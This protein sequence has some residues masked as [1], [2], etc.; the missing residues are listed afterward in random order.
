MTD[1]VDVRP[2][3]KALAEAGSIGDVKD[4]RDRAAAAEAYA[5]EAK[6][7]E[8]MDHA[9]E[10]RLTAERKAGE[11]LREMAERGEREGRGGDRRSK[12]RETT[13]VSLADLGLTKH[14]S[15]RWQKLAELDDGA[16][17]ER[18]AEARA[19]AWAAIE[20]TAAERQAE[21][22]ERREAREAE[23]GARQAALPEK[24]Y[25]VILGDPEWRDEVWSRETGLDRAPDNHYPTSDIEAIKARDVGS[26]AADDCVLLLWSTIQHLALALEVMDG[27]GFAYKSHVVWLKPSIGLGR[28]IRSR[29]EILLIGTRGD[30][31]CPAPGEQWESVIEAPRG[32]HS[33]KPPAFYELV[34]AYFPNLPKVELNARGERRVGWDVWGNE[35][36]P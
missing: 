18:L 29:H 23:L 32:E 9:V 27:W 31:P 15:A 36:A 28:W 1:L 7:R 14:Q 30:P 2:A 11:M 17:L 35:A 34:E 24:R 21:K 16:F 13:L 10:V 22:R 33:A 19:A 6:N 20:L 5:R 25:G 26:I 3:F 12:S 8:L 4:V